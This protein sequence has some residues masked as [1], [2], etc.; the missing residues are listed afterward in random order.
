M[1]GY[2]IKNPANLYTINFDNISSSNGDIF[3]LLGNT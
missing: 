3:L 1:K 2:L